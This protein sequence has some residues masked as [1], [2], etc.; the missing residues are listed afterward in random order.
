MLNWWAWLSPL[1]ISYSSVRGSR[2]GCVIMG[3]PISPSLGLSFP[4]GGGGWTEK[5]SGPQKCKSPHPKHHLPASAKPHSP[6]PSR[7]QGRS[8][9]SRGGGGKGY[10]SEVRGWRAA[11]RSLRGGR[12]EGPSEK[13]SPGGWSPGKGTGFNAKRRQERPRASAWVGEEGR[14]PWHA[15]RDAA[16]AETQERRSGETRRPRPSGGTG[17][18]G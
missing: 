11:V 14:G 4:R 7:R 12:A 3:Q 17:G 6:A 16:W 2:T 1:K 15:R 5:G 10:P 18:R 9:S 8:K 13:V